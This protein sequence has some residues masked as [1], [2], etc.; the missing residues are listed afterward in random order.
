VDKCFGIVVNGWN[1][2][3]AVIRL[4]DLKVSS[5]GASGH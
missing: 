5:A 3:S 4:I 1:A 2:P